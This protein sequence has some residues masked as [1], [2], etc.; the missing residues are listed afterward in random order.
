MKYFD[1]EWEA[2]EVLMKH[3]ESLMQC[4]GAVEFDNANDLYEFTVE[5]C[6]YILTTNLIEGKYDS[7]QFSKVRNE[8]GKLLNKLFYVKE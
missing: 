2:R 3:N 5:E 8:L 7:L 4:G 1:P 6:A